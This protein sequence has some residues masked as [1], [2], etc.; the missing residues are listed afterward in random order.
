[1]DR[2][3]LLAVIL[4]TVVLAIGFYFQGV[5]FPPEEAP[6]EAPSES[7]SQENAE[8][9]DTNTS[10][11][12]ADERES[13]VERPAEFEGR[14]DF[15][16]RGFAVASEEE[17]SPSTTPVEY[18][19]PGFMR[20]ILDPRGA[21]ITS[22][23]LLSHT[24]NGEPL[25]FFFGESDRSGLTMTLGGI[26]GELIDPVFNLRR[27]E[28]DR[29]FEFYQTLVIRGYE[30]QPFE[31]LKR[32]T[33]AEGEYL[34]ELDVEL[35]NSVN[36]FVPLNFDGDAYTLSIGP[37]I[38]PAFEELAGR[39]AGADFRKFSYLDGDRRRDITN[40]ANG[41]RQSL[42]ELSPWAA[43]N[44]KYF[45]ALAT[46]GN[47]GSQVVFGAEPTGEGIQG[48]QLHLVRPALESSRV[49]DTFRFYFGPKSA[50]VLSQYENAEDN[51]FGIRDLQFDTLIESSWL[52]W[53]ERPLKWLLDM[54]YRLIPNWGVSIILL[55]ILVKLVLYP[56]TRKSYESTAKMREIGPKVSALKEKFG[57]DAQKLNAA[58][59]ELYKK[60]GVNPLGGC[61]P[62][63]LQFPFFIAMFSLFNN[64]FDLRG[65]VF[66][67]GWI[68]DLS[69]PEAIVNFPFTIPLLGW[70]ALRLLPII[71]VATQ[72]ISTKFTQPAD[73]SQ[74]NAQM[75]M[76]TLGMPI[77]FFFIMYN[78][79]SGLLVYWIFQ[80]IITTGQQLLY[81]F[82]THKKA[83]Q[84]AH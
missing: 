78:M 2:K 75:K 67:P 71:F 60:E 25:D 81:N 49:N 26:D 18:V 51:F 59:M 5:F 32:Y 54:F 28:G 48:S 82:F 44:G 53:L 62:I 38:A 35:R 9:A 73:A 77:M 43:V 8:P 20:V 83:T 30:D 52:G 34:F 70:D 46:M 29:V 15:N 31:L 61:L 66:I 80:N 79:P 40:I 16:G 14:Y 47:T 69:S 84:A 7:V 17:S 56:L 58:T 1:M 64:H 12:G 57:D 74:N 45:M 3:T 33:F 23:Q 76:M 21:N 19:D 42:E 6:L 72:L 39:R 10:S 4:S 24:D 50:P 37:Q 22:V 11:A 63:L 13:A 55:T 68:T 36:D 65:A 27:G 41:D